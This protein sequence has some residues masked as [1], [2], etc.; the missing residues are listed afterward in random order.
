MTDLGTAILAAGL[1]ASA[2]ALAFAPRAT[3][4]PDLRAGQPSTVARGW[5]VL[6]V[7]LLAG[8]WWL[9]RAGAPGLPLRVVGPGAVLLAAGAG[10]LALRRAGHRRFVR[11]ETSARVLEVC[12][13]IAG[14][15]SAGVAPVLALERAAARWPALGPVASAQRFG[16][17]VPEAMRALSASPGAG[18]LALVAAAWQLTERSGAGLAEALGSV[19]GGLRQQQRT[20]RVVAAELS[21]AR[22]TA[23]LIAFLPVLTLAT[24]SGIGSPI[25]FLFGT[26]AG[27]LCLSGGLSLAFL[28]LGWIERIAAALEQET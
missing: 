24:G 13:E 14:E 9:S 6:A 16:G 19:S 12:D 7:L 3:S 20:R 23:R 25:G 28:G 10:V 8:G 26:S 18:D 1:A 22:A 15:L 21:S 17:S 2:V 27:L 11:R 4:A 5:P